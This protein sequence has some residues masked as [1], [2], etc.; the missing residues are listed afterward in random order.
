M[1]TML[2]L[3]PVRLI[4]FAMISFCA[5]GCFDTLQAQSL[6]V[7]NSTLA[8]TAAQGSDPAPPTQSVSVGTST[9]SSVQFTITT[10]LS[11][12]SNWLFAGTGQF[13]GNSG[14]APGTVTVQVTS[15]SLASGTYNG[16]ITLTPNNTSGAVVISVALTVT[17]TNA[18]SFLSSSP[19]Q[20]SYGFELGHS[21]P[22]AQTSQIVSSGIVLPLNLSIS[23]AGT[24]NCPQGWLQATLSGTTTPATLTVSIVN[25]SSGLGA[26]SC[27]GLVSVSSNTPANGTTSTQIG[28]TLF[29]SN[30]ALLN[31][32]I[33]PGLTNVTLQR[34]GPPV[35]FIISLS[36][37]DTSSVPFSTSVTSG[38]AWLAPPAPASGSTPTGGGSANLDVQITPGTIL[39]V[40]TYQ[41]SI[42]ITSP[43]LLNNTLTIPITLNITS[44][45]SVTIT[46][47]GTQ[48]FTEAQG[49]ALPAPQTLMMTG[50]VSS[51]FTTSIQ[52]GAAGGGWLQVSPTSGN[53]N[54]NS[55]T[56]IVL[57]VAQNSLLQGT[58]SSQV[59]ISF[60]NS[61]IPSV[62][63]FVSL[64]VQPPSPALV[65]TPSALSFSFQ[66][67]ST[68]PAAQSISITNPAAG[69]LAFAV[70]AVSDSWIS[71]TPSSGATPGSIFVSVSPQS[72]QPG[73]Y[74]GS[75]TLISSGVPT[76]TVNVSLFVSANQTPQPFIISNAASGIG[77]Q[78]SPGEIITIKGTGLGPGNPVSFNLSTLTSPTLAGVGVTFDG[79]PGTLL[80][81]SS[82]QI[83]VTVPYEIAGRSSTTVIVTYQGTPSS[84]IVQPAG[85]ASLGLFTNNA[86]GSGQAAVI[87][88]NY[89]FN[90][91]SAPAP[92]GSY[93][94]VYA[95][96]G[97]QTN[98][99]STDGEVS[100][101]TSLLPLV[102]QS[103]ITAT[104][105]GKSAPV[106]FAGAAPGY[107]TGVVQFNI[108]VPTGVTGNALPIVVTINGSTLVQSQT[109]AT[110]AVQ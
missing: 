1:L 23:T 82:T 92:Q 42:Q 19:S 34:G 48:S 21:L 87:N 52:Q 61:T 13:S 46:P 55:A 15:A 6:T 9:G 54:S 36:S 26:G 99:A 41:G 86:T 14:T 27:T 39:S 105:G 51:S 53:L 30:S 107:V 4:T 74:S 88:Q 98:P 100:P 64:T 110:V 95:T 12:G 11:S 102:S 63:L 50:P 20:L 60:Q 80:Y 5:V 97:G 89:T 40:G 85:T 25:P 38:Q 101:T 32:S 47:G 59:T 78:L 18:T 69:N 67:G 57:S 83:N 33:P 49:G 16:T 68:P 79:F 93:I 8:F 109:T 70:G 71:V 72:L 37:T 10:T 31:V 73:S 108:Q 81:V 66:G 24:N 22:V 44:M 96:G 17:G 75:F 35:Q 104:I 56:S 3:A 77:G 106:V 65:A 29:I 43:G 62:V 2:R 103:V 91:S 76:T 45:S 84:G 58:Y 90:T 28:V 7:S 94:S